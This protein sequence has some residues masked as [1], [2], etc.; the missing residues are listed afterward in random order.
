MSQEE[1]PVEKR[2]YSI[3]EVASMLGVNASTLR[4]W[5]SQMPELKPRKGANGRRV[6]TQEDIEQLRLIHYLLKVRKY[7][8]QGAREKLQ[9]NPEEISANRQ[10]RETLLKLRE[11]LVSVR[12]SL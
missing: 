5:D 4:F 1:E 7:T 9:M 12:E 6:F 8:I 10:T 11:F 2:Y 3:G